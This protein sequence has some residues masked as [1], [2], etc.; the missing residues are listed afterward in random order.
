MQ[1]F[2]LDGSIPLSATQAIKGKN[3][4]CP[5]CQSALRVR[6]GPHRQTHFYHPS[7]P[8]D[9]RQHQKSPPHLQLQLNLLN[10]IHP[11]EGQIECAFPSIGRI[12]DVA[13]HTR[14]IIFEIQCS[15]IPIAEA[16]SRNA[17]YLKEGY[18]V[19]WILHDRCFN[20]RNLSASEFYLRSTPCYFT[21]V[22]AKGEGIIYDQFEV[23]KGHQRVF[24]GPCLKI[25]LPQV[26]FFS[27]S[28][29]STELPSVLKLRISSWKCFVLKDL[30]SRWIQEKDKNQ[31]AAKMAV[32]ETQI[33][34]RNHVLKRLPFLKLLRLGYG[35]LLRF[36][37]KKI[38]KK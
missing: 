32:L 1:L 12:A 25:N 17:D 11:E 5:E 23:I 27:P 36:I 15:P 18:Q 7:A 34:N 37:L 29:I 8:K 13:W 20:Q 10:L 14:K 35:S 22:N 33:L 3:Y 6:S 31:I 21:N 26:V 4:F 2:A 9:C 30:Y 28:E 24:K 38:S 19:I 16:E